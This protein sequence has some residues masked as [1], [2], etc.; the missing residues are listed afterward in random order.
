M[1]KYGTWTTICSPTQKQEEAEKYLF[2][3]FEKIGGYV[4]EKSNPH[5]FGAYPSFEVD[6]PQKFEFI[7]DP[8]FDEIDEDGEKLLLEWDAWTEKANEI[9][10]NYTK[11]FADYL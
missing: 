4:F 2:N 6:K 9:E 11:K 8:D 1:S 3:E 5:D 10:A 7:P